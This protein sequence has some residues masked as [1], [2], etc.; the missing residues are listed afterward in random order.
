MQLTFGAFYA[1]DAHL[2]SCSLPPHG[3][4]TY[5]SGLAISLLW[6]ETSDVTV[7]RGPKCA[8]ATSSEVASQVIATF[9]LWG[10][11]RYTLAHQQKPLS[12]NMTTDALHDLG[13]LSHILLT[14]GTCRDAFAC[15]IL[16][17]RPFGVLAVLLL[18]DNLQ[19]QRQACADRVCS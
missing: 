5:S 6:S 10:S 17:R 9:E 15:M 13:R 3:Y 4:L 16:I 7:A 12:T 19:S 18:L 11:P 2:E 14:S 1:R 8:Q